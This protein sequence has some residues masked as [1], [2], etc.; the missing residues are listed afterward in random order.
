MPKEESVSIPLPAGM[1]KEE[2]LKLFS[3]FQK[4]RV[5]GKQRDTAIR[6]ATKRLIAAHQPEYDRYY[7]EEY[8]KAGGV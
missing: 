3:T 1:T 5:T 2:F 4:A 7:N 8:A 6:A